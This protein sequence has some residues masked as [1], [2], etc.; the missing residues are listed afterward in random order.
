LS[1]LDRKVGQGLFVFP[2]F[3]SDLLF[4][5]VCFFLLLALFPEF[6]ISR[7]L[8]LVCY[9]RHSESVHRPWLTVHFR[10]FN[11]RLTIKCS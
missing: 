10:S 7:P 11:R 2:S 4:L 9:S 1:L 3:V 8:G 6:T 5:F